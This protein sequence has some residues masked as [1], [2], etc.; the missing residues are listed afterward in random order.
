[1]NFPDRDAHDGAF[2]SLELERLVRSLSARVSRASLDRPAAPSGEVPVPIRI[3]IVGAGGH[4]AVVADILLRM[5]AAGL[6]ID[7]VACVDDG[8]KE[9]GCLLSVPFVA[10]G[11]AALDR[12]HH[13]AV[14]VAIGANS[15]RRRIVE[16]LRRAGETLASAVHPSSI[17]ASDVVIGPG[18]VVCA[19]VV[20]N[21]GARIG[22][23]AIVNTQSSVD[24]HCV[25]GDYVHVAP[26]S[27]LGGGVVVGDGTLLGIGSTVLPGK[28]IGSHVV[29]GAGSVVTADLPSG[30]LA[31]GLP[32]RIRT[33][34]SQMVSA[35]PAI[36]SAS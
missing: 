4:G 23:G 16:A 30:V 7:P 14:I 6:P 3:I 11:M 9:G 19:G 28:R 25:I 32:A 12:I 35:V 5:R 20:L 34:K 31:Y 21:P 24:H 36:A 33:P 22:S 8:R 2:P 26:G 29:V 10:G 27:H 18:T 1:M 15:T 13:D 17:L